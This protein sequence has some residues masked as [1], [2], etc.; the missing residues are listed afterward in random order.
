MDLRQ[1][2]PTLLAVL[3]GAS[4]TVH[5]ASPRTFEPLIPSW[6]PRPR[7]VV[8]ASGVAEIVCAGGLLARARWARSASVLLLLGVFPGN[9]QVAVTASRL[10]PSRC[11]LRLALAIARLPLQIPL[12][13]AAMQ[14][15]RSEI[16]GKDAI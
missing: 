6:L 1:R 2:A 11:T 12:V 3:F 9:V 5:L 10:A 4:G 7:A 8:Y 13:W 14:C 16:P 15:G